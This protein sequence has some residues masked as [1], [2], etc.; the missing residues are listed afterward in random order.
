MLCRKAC[1]ECTHELPGSVLTSILSSKVS[2]Q[3]HTSITTQV[4]WRLESSTCKSRVICHRSES[5]K[6]LWVWVTCGYLPFVYME[7]SIEALLWLL[8]S[9]WLITIPV[10]SSASATSLPLTFGCLLLSWNEIM[11]SS[12]GIAEGKSHHEPSTVA[13]QVDSSVNKCR[14]FD[15]VSPPH[16]N[17]HSTSVEVAA[18][19]R[20]SEFRICE[21]ACYMY[22][23][24]KGNL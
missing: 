15:M 18:Q 7:N 17:A 9:E 8:Y 2:T 20:C 14:I 24:P 4:D 13:A 10:E 21:D 6:Y 11:M 5:H 1:H 3:I 16:E 22:L 12:Q 19:K 23:V